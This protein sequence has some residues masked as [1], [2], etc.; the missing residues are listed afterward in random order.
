MPNPAFT[1]A[2]FTQALLNLMPPGRAWNRDP[3]SVQTKAIA[4]YAPTFRRNSDSAVGLIAD[5]FPSSTVNLLPEWEATLGLPDP[6]AGIAP[7]LQA[8]RAQVKARFCATG[9]QSVSDFETYAAGLG[10]TITIRQYTPFRM[11]SGACGQP[12]GGL[13]WLYTWAIET[14]KNTITPFRTGSARVGEAL[15][16][17]GNTVLECEMNA[18]KPAHTILQ[19]HYS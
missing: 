11:G 6:C 2:D 12:L 16:S 10:Y 8:R 7:T 13:D 15:T 3:E 17:W 14:T 1:D 4:S 18:I 5:A 9:G 19:F